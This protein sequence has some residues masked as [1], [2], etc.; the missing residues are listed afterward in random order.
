MD[1]KTKN[2]L[3]VEEN[4]PTDWFERL[5]SDA[6]EGGEG[7]PWANMAPHP[8]FKSWI[9]DNPN[10]QKGKTALVIGCGMG[11]DAIEL[12]SQ[13]FKVTAFDVSNSAIELCKTRFP[14]AEVKF[15]QADL[16]EGISDWNRKFDFVLEIYTIQAL[17]PKYEKT[18]IKNISDFVADN[19]KLLVITETQEGKRTFENGPPW[20]LNH[21]YLESFESCGLKQIFHSSN[22]ETEMGEATHLTIFQRQP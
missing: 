6:D 16:L 4:K 20:L 12:E 1:E 9:S 7:V 19:G 15:I 3:G 18:L 21:E 14:N 22:T 8:V 13:G 11:D 2:R 17:P 5:Y 10:T